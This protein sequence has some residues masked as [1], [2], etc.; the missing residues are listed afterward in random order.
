MNRSTGEPL[1]DW[2]RKRSLSLVAFGMFLLA[3]IGQAVAGRAHYNQE[4]AD[5]GEPPVGMLEYLGTGEFGEATFENWESEFLQM[6]M[7]IFLTA[8]LVQVGSAESRKPEGEPGADEQAVDEPPERHRDDPDA[9]WPVRHGGIALS[10][11]KRSLSLVLF[12][13]FLISFAGHAAAGAADYNEEARAHG[14]EALSV[15]AYATS[16]RF[17]FESFQNWQSEFL[18]VWAIAVLSIW[19]RQQGS[20][21]SKPVHVPYESTG[22]E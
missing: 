9:P 18:A 10:L 15:L 6:A 14:G 2:I 22:S 16:A 19:F 11:Y 5:H 12:V 13:L 4:Q 3:M 7:F 8:M 20:P 21:E 17:W 1:A